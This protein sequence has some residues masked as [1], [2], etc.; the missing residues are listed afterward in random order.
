[1]LGTFSSNPGGMYL[2]LTEPVDIDVAPDGNVFVSNS[3]GS[4]GPDGQLWRFSSDL[5]LDWMAPA[6]VWTYYGVVAI[7]DG[8][9]V[10]GGGT[11]LIR[12]GP[13]GNKITAVQVPDPL[14]GLYG[15]WLADLSPSGDRVAILHGAW[16]DETSQ[17][18]VSVW[19][20]DAETLELASA[21]W[22]WPAG[23]VVNARLKELVHHDGATWVLGDLPADDED[24]PHWWPTL[25]GVGV[26]ENS[27]S[28]ERSFVEF[29]HVHQ[30]ARRGFAVRDDGVMVLALQHTLVAL[31]SDGK[32]LWHIDASD[33]EPNAAASTNPTAS[34]FADAVVDADGAMFVGSVS[35]P[36]FACDRVAWT[37]RVS[38]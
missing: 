18:S 1:S 29:G 10:L 32:L 17:H 38:W 14:L 6:D 7:D 21:P 13:N 9:I 30:D 4:L 20:Y 19:H 36:A 34:S 31:D 8:A 28:I 11:E 35:M 25:W 24:P 3:G 15:F 23:N 33:I 12:V 37:G 16:D 27:P 5:E 22:Q 26:G 2:P